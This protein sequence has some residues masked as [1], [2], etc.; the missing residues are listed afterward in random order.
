M[1]GRES[2]ESREIREIRDPRELP[3]R[4]L[5]QPRTS[6]A[7]FICEVPAPPPI[8]LRSPQRY[9]SWLAA[10]AG[11]VERAAARWDALPDGYW[12]VRIDARPAE[13]DGE[14]VDGLRL[15]E[16]VRPVVEL[17]VSTGIVADGRYVWH[18]E[19]E[20]VHP[21]RERRVAEGCACVS[22]YSMMGDAQRP[23]MQGP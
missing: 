22:V 23:W 20:R 1:D 11:E 15:D 21:G 3:W 6:A 10:A 7:I 8:D 12:G 4:G 18:C 14:P 19:I 16:M 2:R 9:M 17:L 13:R 5:S